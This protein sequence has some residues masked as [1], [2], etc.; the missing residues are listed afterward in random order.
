MLI[1]PALLGGQARDHL[2]DTLN[3]ASSAHQ[4]DLR[5]KLPEIGYIWKQLEARRTR[6]PK[7][8]THLP[9]I[10][11]KARQIWGR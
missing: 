4:T 6:G 9:G 7:S 2:E 8:G 1:N 3:L 5:S 11:A 10:A